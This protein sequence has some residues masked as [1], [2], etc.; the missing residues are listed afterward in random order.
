MRGEPLRLAWSMLWRATL[1]A[2]LCFVLGSLAL[3]TWLFRFVGPV[4]LGAMALAGQWTWAGAGL[5]G[6][7]G[8]LALWRW[9][10]LRRMLEWPH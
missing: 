5:L 8:S 7:V 3:A 10:R 6:W 1:L 9:E 2:P 4:W